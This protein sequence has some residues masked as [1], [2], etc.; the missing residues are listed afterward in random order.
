MKPDWYAGDD[1]LKESLWIQETLLVFILFMNQ[2]R[3][4]AEVLLSILC[5]SCI[6]S[7]HVMYSV[8]DQYMKYGVF[9]RHFIFLSNICTCEQ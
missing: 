6:V 9:F 1:G 2:P 5:N 3:Q 4:P 8:Y 7:Y